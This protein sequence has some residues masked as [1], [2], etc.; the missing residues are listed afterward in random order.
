MRQGGVRRR[1]LMAGSM[2]AAPPGAVA[3]GG[4][5]GLGREG[6]QGDIVQT[7][8]HQ[9]PTDHHQHGLGR[10]I[11]R[12]PISVV[13]PTLNEERNL[14]HVL[15]GLS[16]D[17][18]VILV[19][20]HSTDRTVEVAQTLRPSLRIIRQTG[21]GKGDALAEGF[22]VATGE[23]IVTF[24]ADGSAVA[25]EIP[26]F[27][28]ALLAG[29]DF[30]KGSRYLQGGGS[31]D[32]T[33]LR[34]FGNRRLTQLVNVLYGTKYTDLCY[35][36]SAFW[37]RLVPLFH[38]DGTGFEVETLTTLWVA[39]AGL[40]VTEIPSY[41]RS[42]ICGSSN[43]NTFRDGWRVLRIIL[44]ERLAKYPAIPATLAS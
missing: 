35:G 2:P 5:N 44:R 43:L 15:E 17:Y 14:P 16:E 34:S 1:L 30:V 32:L 41:E 19:D 31:D 11:D 8:H 27:V 24:D 13:I 21:R 33:L 12:P 39:K 36:Y 6:R 28:D 38:L 18:E 20:G 7:D 9:V 25:K 29:A 3:H 42:R 37:R 23:V 22:R 26:E 10:Y 40:S 4:D